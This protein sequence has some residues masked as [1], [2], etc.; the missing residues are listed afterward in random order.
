MTIEAWIVRPSCTCKIT[1]PWFEF[2]GMKPSLSCWL[3]L[4]MREGDDA[5]GDILNGQSG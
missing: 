1:G 4:M 5:V 2:H 3:L